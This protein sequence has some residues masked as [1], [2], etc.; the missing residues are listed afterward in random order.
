MNRRHLSIACVLLFCFV[1]FM[2]D[3]AVAEKGTGILYK[4]RDVAKSNINKAIIKSFADITEEEEYYIGRAV[5]ANILSKYSVYNNQAVTQYINYVGNSVVFYS[6]R[7]EIYAGYHFLILDVEEVNAF[8]A[9]GGFVFITKGLLK[10]CQDEEMLACVLA[11][12]VGH[13]CANHGLKSIKKSHLTEAF[14]LIGMQ[15]VKKYGTQELTKL[16]GIFENVLGDI[17]KTLVER[18]YDRKYEYEADKLA[19]RIAVNT[20]YSPSG[21]KDFLETMVD[22]SSDVS[23]KGWFK[24]HPKANDRI[25]RVKNEISNIKT[26]PLKDSV[27]TKRFLQSIKTIQ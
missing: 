26:T 10:R 21:L 8:A 9:P 15:A 24:T 1:F 25:A 11:H 7:P 12:E 2:D 6:E 17:M 23:G 22:D 18:G 13:I 27:R 14:R 5:A 20:G 3:C 19:V 16:T 4:A